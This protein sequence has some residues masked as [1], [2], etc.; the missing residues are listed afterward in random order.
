L[1]DL[2]KVVFTHIAIMLFGGCWGMLFGTCC[3]IKGPEL[4]QKISTACKLV[5]K[6]D[7]D[8]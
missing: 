8:G 5:T 7:R 1:E 3:I 4:K 6:Q 2:V